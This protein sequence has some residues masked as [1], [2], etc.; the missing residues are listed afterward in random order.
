MTRAKLGLVIALTSALGVATLAA[1]CWSATH[2]ETSRMVRV[3][4][5]LPRPAASAAGAE[6]EPSRRNSRR[7][8]R[9]PVSVDPGLVHTAVPHRPPSRPHRATCS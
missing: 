6:V 3:P 4:Q 9:T 8:R 5:P 7:V 1:G 2:S